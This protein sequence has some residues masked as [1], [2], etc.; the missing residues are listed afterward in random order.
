MKRIVFDN[1]KP[2]EILKAIEKINS[3]ENDEISS[4]RLQLYIKK[5]INGQNL[6]E[7]KLRKV[8]LGIDEVNDFLKNRD[9][10]NIFYQNLIVLFD[11]IPLTNIDRWIFAIKNSLFSSYEESKY[12]NILKNSYSKKLDKN[13]NFS[14]LGNQHIYKYIKSNLDMESF[15]IENIY[16]YFIQ[17]SLGIES[18]Y[19][20]LGIPTVSSFYYS[21]VQ[22]MIKKNLLEVAVGKKIV[23]TKEEK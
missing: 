22:R 23:Y 12:H 11:E 16:N 19:E 13:I 6:Q 4:S 2:K 7:K 17:S 3:D 1:F 10:I 5:I 15:Y 20:E 21:S 14:S 8:F 9:K 18:I